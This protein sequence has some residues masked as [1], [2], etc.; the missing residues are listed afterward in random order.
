MRCVVAV[1]VV[2]FVAGCGT[3]DASGP[4]AT[5]RSTSSGIGRAVLSPAT[6]SPR[7]DECSEQLHFRANGTAG[8]ITCR[9]G[10]LNALAWTYYEK[11]DP[12]VLTI[13]PKASPDQVLRAMCSDLHGNTKPLVLDTYH[14]AL[15]YYGWRFGVN[16]AQA[17]EEDNC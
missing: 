4:S 14:L 17:F 1:A 16:P 12:L 15:R 8:P 3:G 7:V 2:G 11:V 5:T 13:G 9:G 10:R 6:V